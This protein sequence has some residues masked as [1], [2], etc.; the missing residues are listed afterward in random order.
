MLKYYPTIWI[1]AILY[2][3]KKHI[4]IIG[5]FKVTWSWKEKSIV[6]EMSSRKITLVQE[7]IPLKC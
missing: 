2:D 7:N 5:V 4:W 1:V 3:F 6:S